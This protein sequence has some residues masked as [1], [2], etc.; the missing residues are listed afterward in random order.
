MVGPGADG[1]GDPLADPLPEALGDGLDSPDAWDAPAEA[2]EAAGLL[3]LLPVET[4]P[5]MAM[6]IRRLS[7]DAAIKKGV[8]RQ[9]GV[10]R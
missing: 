3:V 6:I 1:L 9:K 5:T 10:R 8:R 2:A 7:G 4:H